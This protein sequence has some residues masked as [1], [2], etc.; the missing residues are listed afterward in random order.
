VKGAAWLAGLTVIVLTA[1]WTVSPVMHTRKQMQRRTAS[2]PDLDGFA[3]GH[4]AVWASEAPIE[5]LLG[6]TDRLVEV[7]TRGELN[8]GGLAWL[9]TNTPRESPLET[10][11][12]RASL[13]LVLTVTD[14]ESAPVESA[15]ARAGRR[16]RFETRRVFARVDE[17]IKNRS[18]RPVLAGTSIVFDY[19]GGGETEIGGTRVVTRRESERLP[20]RGRQYLWFLGA[21]RDSIFGGS[22]ASAFDLSGRRVT[23]LARGPRRATLPLESPADALARVRRRATLPAL[24]EYELASGVA[25]GVVYERTRTAVR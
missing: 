3:P 19:E 18:A 23:P 20:E 14:L 4:R 24:R 2:T 17:V 7:V 13:V 8:D 22:A 5:T 10:A 16:P 15:E 9:L 25:R 1:T 6:P 12:R 11:P 21:T